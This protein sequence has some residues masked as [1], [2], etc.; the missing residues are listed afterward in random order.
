MKYHCTIIRILKYKR[1]IIPSIVKYVEELEIS[2]TSGKNVK[3]CHHIGE[4]AVYQKLKQ[5]PNI[6][7]SQSTPRYLLKKNKTCVHT[8]FYMNIYS[9]FIYSSQ[10]KNQ[11]K[12]P[13][14]S[15]WINKSYD[16]I[17][18]YMKKKEIVIHATT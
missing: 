17:L 13:S 5:T 9:S 2:Y 11:P 15:D 4:L 6:W 16:R 14:R 3:W 1:L 8:V 7:P 12:C 10:F 18:L